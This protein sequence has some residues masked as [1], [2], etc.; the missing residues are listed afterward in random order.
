MLSSDHL[1]VNDMGKMDKPS[2]PLLDDVARKAGVSP[3]LVSLALRNKPGPSESRRVAILRAAEELGYRA[4]MAASLLAKSRPHRIGVALNLTQSFH[5]EAADHIYQ[6]AREMGYDVLLGGITDSRPLAEATSSLV[7]ESSEGVL[8]VGTHIVPTSLTE[9][10]NAVPVVVL[11]HAPWNGKYDIVRT[12]GGEGMRSAVNMLASRGHK[13]IA[14]IDGR[15]YSGAEERRIGYLQGMEENGLERFSVIQPG[16][17]RE[18]DGFNASAALLEQHPDVTG[19]VCYNDSCAVGAVRTIQR[20]RLNV[21]ND[22][23]VIGYDDSPIAR[24]D[25]FGLTTLAQDTPRLASIAVKRLVTL[26]EHTETP[27]EHL[28]FPPNLIERRSAGPAK[29]SATRQ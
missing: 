7:S 1:L 9:G 26:I 10:A 14:H 4:N 17:N 18:Q 6:A 15:D 23:S 20:K 19:I 13:R 12:D 5:V 16:G 22:I 11:G 29:R 2:R 25:Y 27:H 24:M 8:L 3:S 28:V 21:P